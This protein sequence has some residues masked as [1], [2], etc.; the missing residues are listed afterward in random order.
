MKETEIEDEG[1]DKKT[2]EGLSLYSD[3]LKYLKDSGQYKESEDDQE[4]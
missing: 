1:L 4:K 2:I 3:H